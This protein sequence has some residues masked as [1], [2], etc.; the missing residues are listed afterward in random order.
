MEVEVAKEYSYLFYFYLAS[1]NNYQETCL[2]TAKALEMKIPEEKIPVLF[3]GRQDVLPAPTEI[4]QKNEPKSITVRITI[5]MTLEEILHLV[6]TEKMSKVFATL[7]AYEANFS[8]KS[9]YYALKREFT[10]DK[11][12]IKEADIRERLA[13]F[14]SMEKEAIEKGNLAY[15]NPKEVQSNPLPVQ[16]EYKTLLLEKHA[17]F[18]KEL[19]ITADTSTKFELKKRIEDIDEEL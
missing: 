7:D 17:Y 2:K 13:V 1:G 5:K 3:M 6:E 9:S 4:E 11:N 10:N 14:L 19:A 12:G 16:D 15:P 18:R 8:S